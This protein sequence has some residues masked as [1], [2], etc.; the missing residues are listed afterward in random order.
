VICSIR[1]DVIDYILEKG[2]KCGGRFGVCIP[3]T[4]RSKNE[5]SEARKNLVIF[6][7]LEWTHVAARVQDVG[8]AGAPDRIA[9]RMHLEKVV[10]HRGPSLRG[11]VRDV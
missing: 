11:H 9:I 7:V 2:P 1:G 8:T 10:W 6:G 5:C 4:T 3:R